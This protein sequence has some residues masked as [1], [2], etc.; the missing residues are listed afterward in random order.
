[1]PQAL[2][3][4]VRG[5]LRRPYQKSLLD[6]P[7]GPNPEAAGRPIRHEELE[8]SLHGP[9]QSNPQAVPRTLDQRLVPTDILVI[10][11]KLEEGVD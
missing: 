7:R 8:K 1:M 9:S 4:S 6:G 3:S 2:P 5:E 10:G 11:R